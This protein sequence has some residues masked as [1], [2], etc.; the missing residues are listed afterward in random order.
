MHKRKM[1][2]RFRWRILI[3]STSLAKRFSPLLARR[4][5]RANSRAEAVEVGRVCGEAAKTCSGK[6]VD[7]RLHSCNT[8]L[9][10]RVGCEPPGNCRAA[11]LP[12]RNELL[13]HSDNAMG[14]DAGPD[15]IC[16]RSSIRLG[17][18]RKTEL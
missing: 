18:V 8:V 4:R 7:L 11:L 14:T 3:R 17:F 15:C 9:F 10:T 12:L 16:H 1:R 13:E 6:A 2:H 5:Q